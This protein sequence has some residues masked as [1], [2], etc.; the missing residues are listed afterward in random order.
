M[1]VM[2]QSCG[3]LTVSA[4]QYTGPL[5]HTQSRVEIHKMSPAVVVVMTCHEFQKH[6]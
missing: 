5:M 1:T 2:L 4:T 6:M 3:S